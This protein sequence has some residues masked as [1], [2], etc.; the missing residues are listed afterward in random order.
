MLSI[1]LSRRKCGLGRKRQQPKQQKEEHIYENRE[2]EPTGRSS[3]GEDGPQLPE[4]S[5]TKRNREETH[6]L[7]RRHRGAHRR[8]RRG[9]VCPGRASGAPRSEAMDHPLRLFAFSPQNF[10]RSSTAFSEDLFERPRAAAPGSAPVTSPGSGRL[11][12]RTENGRRMRPGP[13]RG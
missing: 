10:A 3:S 8:A 6:P 12:R 7:H 2:A 9:A 1:K 13:A 11:P 5:S 4:K